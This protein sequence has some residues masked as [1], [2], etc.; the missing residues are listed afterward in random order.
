MVINLGTVP[1]LFCVLHM[2]SYCTLDLK[3][4]VSIL[5]EFDLSSHPFFSSQVK[6]CFSL[7]S[8]TGMWRRTNKYSYCQEGGQGKGY[9]TPVSLD[10]VKISGCEHFTRS[11][12]GAKGENAVQNYV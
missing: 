5:L 8:C 9:C 3:S 2:I 6:E 7:F 11:L 12:V 4:A 1:H 10:Y